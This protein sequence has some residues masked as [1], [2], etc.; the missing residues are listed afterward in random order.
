[1]Y[2]RVSDP[3]LY[4]SY[5]EKPAPPV[6]RQRSEMIGNDRHTKIPHQTT[7]H[8]RRESSVR[9]CPGLS[10]KNKIRPQVRQLP[11]CV[12]GMYGGVTAAPV[13][14]LQRTAC[15]HL[16]GG[17]ARKYSEMI[18]TQK[19]SAPNHH[20]RKVGIQRPA[21]S[22]I[23]A[24]NRN[25]TLARNRQHPTVIP[26]QSGIRCPRTPTW[27]LSPD[28]IGGNARKRSEMLGESAILAL[29]RHIA[30]REETGPCSRMDRVPGLRESRNPTPR[31]MQA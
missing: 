1:M 23:P 4:Q 15:P 17:N 2:A 26:V 13:S 9:Q 21:M 19:I 16:I 3:P 11:N 10:A 18:G 20:S 29:H 7:I 27:N 22:V 30:S 5:S 14:G 8:Q 25:Q 6:W 24:K 31:C 12:P 28:P